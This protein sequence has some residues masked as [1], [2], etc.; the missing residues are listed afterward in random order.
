MLR[1]AFKEDE[2]SL[3]IAGRGIGFPCWGNA[4]PLYVVNLKSTIKK[5]WLLFYMIKK[6]MSIVSAR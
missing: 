1:P 2:W 6:L 5:N 3:I 4:D